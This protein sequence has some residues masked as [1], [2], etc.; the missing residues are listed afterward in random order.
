MATITFSVLSD[1]ARSGQGEF[2][3]VASSYL[4]SLQ[5]EDM[6]HVLVQSSNVHFHLPRD[7]GNEPIIMIA[8]GTGLAP[9][10]GFIQERAELI[11]RKSSVAPA[12]LYFGCREAGCDD[13]YSDELAEWENAGAVAVRRAYSRGPQASRKYVQ[14]ML[15]ECRDEFLELW[16][17]NAKLYVCGSRA[18]S[19]GVEEVAIC[20]LREAAEKKGDECDESKIKKWWSG[21]RNSRYV[22]DTFD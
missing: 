20:I 18:I 19:Q 8:A 1:R 6:L 14:D 9:F 4:S 15:W 12:L 17:N 7:A 13:L 21:L 2:H 22:V 5:P 3:G 16:E 11:K 10:R